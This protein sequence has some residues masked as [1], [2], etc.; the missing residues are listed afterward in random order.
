LNFFTY[1]DPNNAYSRL[2]GPV[3]LN[4]KGTLVVTDIF[5][6]GGHLT[7]GGS[8]VLTSQR[9]P[10]G[11]FG[12]LTTLWYSDGNGSSYGYGLL[13]STLALNNKGQVLGTAEQNGYHYFLIHDLNTGKTFD[14]RDV[15][16]ANSSTLSL[17]LPPGLIVPKNVYIVNALGLD[18]SGQLL[19]EGALTTESKLHTYLLTPAAV[20]EPSALATLA[21]GTLGL[22]FRRFRDLNGGWTGS[23]ATGSVF[24]TGAVRPRSTG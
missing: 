5:G 23:G 9:Q 10:D 3:L 18:D 19:V 13:A 7:G 1:G 21:L 4:D 12:P 2:V 24:R 15:L 17:D 22:A 16:S 20:P 14:L 11:T 8:Q 6:V